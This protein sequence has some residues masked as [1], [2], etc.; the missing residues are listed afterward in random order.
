MDTIYIDRCE[1]KIGYVYKPLCKYNQ[2]QIWNIV[3]GEEI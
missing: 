2:K 3:S 1:K